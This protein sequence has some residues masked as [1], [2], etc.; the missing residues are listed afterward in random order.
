MNV[1]GFLFDGLST[2]KWSM[3]RNKTLG[4]C[5]Q[6]Q[7]NQFAERGKSN[8]EEREKKNSQENKTP[9][10]RLTPSTANGRNIFFCG[11][12]HRASCLTAAQ[13]AFAFNEPKKKYTENIFVR[14]CAL[15]FVKFISCATIEVF[16]GLFC[17]RFSPLAWRFTSTSV[18]VLFVH[19]AAVCFRFF[20]PPSFITVVDLFVFF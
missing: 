18:N 10:S 9:S 11:M 16:H 6:Q 5:K 14:L 1:N 8:T 7:K 20:S 12:I 15:H 2:H 19:L 3:I 4:R 13:T 17:F